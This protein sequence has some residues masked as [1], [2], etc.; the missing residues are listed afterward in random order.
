MICLP[1]YLSDEEKISFKK[2]KQYQNKIIFY[3]K[4]TALQVINSKAKNTHA[5]YT[6]TFNK[7][8]TVSTPLEIFHIDLLPSQIS[9]TRKSITTF[10]R[11]LQSTFR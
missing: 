5:P 8:S 4:D 1:I 3:I 11:K 9:Y 2:N 6:I 7:H 10:S